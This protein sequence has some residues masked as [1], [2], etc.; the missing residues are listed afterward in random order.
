MLL[1][2]VVF[3]FIELDNNWI[4]SGFNHMNRLGICHMW[5]RTVTIKTV[6]LLRQGLTFAFM[7]HFTISTNVVN[8]K[9]NFRNFSV[10]F[11]PK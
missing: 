4:K 5:D 3:F 8:K 11:F 7:F 1:T 2:S 6:F 10:S 9:G